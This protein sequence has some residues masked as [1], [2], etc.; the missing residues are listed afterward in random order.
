MNKRI[1]N[2][3]DFKRKQVRDS[4]RLNFRTKKG[5]EIVYHPQILN[6]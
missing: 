4:N 5:V 1:C 6:L 3:K 2:E